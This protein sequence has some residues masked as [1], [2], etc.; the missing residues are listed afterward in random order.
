MLRQ[1][2]RP[3]LVQTEEEREVL[4]HEAGLDGVDAHLL[5]GR[6]E[7]YIII[8]LGQVRIVVELGAMGKAARP[9]EDLRDGV[10]RGRV[11]LLVFAV[12]ARHRAV[13]GF[14]FLNRKLDCDLL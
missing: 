8:E 11:A 13:R 6:A 12:M 3:F 10:G 2:V 7:I 4:G 9:G 1:L 14:R 5:Q